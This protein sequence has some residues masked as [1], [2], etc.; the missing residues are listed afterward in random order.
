MGPT[1]TDENEE[2]VSKEFII[3]N[4]ITDLI[5]TFSF[6][7]LTLSSYSQQIAVHLLSIFTH[8]RDEKC[9]HRC[10]S[11]HWHHLSYIIGYINYLLHQ[12]C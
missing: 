5:P 6:D 2:A 1:C 12:V 3:S 10:V 4:K 9:G 11:D 8:H 7:I